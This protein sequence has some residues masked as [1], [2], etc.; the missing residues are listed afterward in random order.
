M[1]L[2]PPRTVV[3]TYCDYVCTV[4]LEIVCMCV[5][6]SYQIYYNV[7]LTYYGEKIQGFAHF[8]PKN[9]N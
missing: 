9:F 1:R 8:E 2:Q 7:L 3:Y 4:P 5:A 6:Q